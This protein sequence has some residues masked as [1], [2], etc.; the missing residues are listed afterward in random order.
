MYSIK[1]GRGPSLG[2]GIGSLAAA[3]F[4]IFWTITAS[5]M[6]APGFFVFFGVCFVIMGLGMA[7]YHFYNA[8]SQNRFS[9]YDITVPGEEVDPL[10][11]G[12]TA[13]KPEVRQHS[14]EGA[15]EKP[16]F[17]PFCGEKLQANFE[18]CP[19]CGADI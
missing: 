9:N 10:D 12:R 18:F 4:G 15:D 7:C 5:S 1:P 16:N 19:K 17:C 8:T 2:G 14:G 13:V 6:G 3:G 11:P